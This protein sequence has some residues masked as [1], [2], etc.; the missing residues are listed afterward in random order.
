MIVKSLGIYDDEVES[1]ILYT[2]KLLFEL[3]E[4]NIL[5]T[6]KLLLELCE[7]IRLI[8]CY[9]FNVFSHD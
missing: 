7:H 3:C 1:N 5:Y 2:I 8:K 4:S 9:F 6:I